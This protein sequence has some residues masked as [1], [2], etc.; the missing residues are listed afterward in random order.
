[1][2]MSRVKC[3]R[4]TATLVSYPQDKTSREL[5][6][7]SRSRSH[8]TPFPNNAHHTEYPGC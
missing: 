6:V 1:M 7:T 3:Q 4:R 5:T 8:T 2:H